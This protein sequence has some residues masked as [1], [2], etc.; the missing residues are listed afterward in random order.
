[1]G[2]THCHPAPRG[3]APFPA[4]E[5]EVLLLEHPPTPFLAVVEMVMA[6]ALHAELAQME[7]EGGQLVES[8]LERDQ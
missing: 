4:V 6:A 7:E 1:M 3:L 8:Q 2:H 5:A